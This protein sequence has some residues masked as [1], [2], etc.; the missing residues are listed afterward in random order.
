M[1]LKLQ[2]ISK[3][4]R[5]IGR[6][7]LPEVR[8]SPASHEVSPSRHSPCPTFV[9]APTRVRH[10]VL[11]L[12][13]SLSFTGAAPSLGPRFA[14]KLLQFESRT[15]TFSSCVATD[16]NRKSTNTLSRNTFAR[17]WS[18]TSRYPGMS[19]TRDGGGLV[20][21][22][23]SCL[24]Q[25]PFAS[26]PLPRVSRFYF[27]GLGITAFVLSTVILASEHRTP[28]GSLGMINSL[29]LETAQPL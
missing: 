22:L 4:Y 20:S 3:T 10:A 5:T 24:I 18:H 25:Q 7:D 19:F 15:L 26:A 21:F 14:I 11:L 9:S 29:A 17:V 2:R 1:R 6:D 12:A 27:L 13:A 23:A 28:F 16:F 8:S